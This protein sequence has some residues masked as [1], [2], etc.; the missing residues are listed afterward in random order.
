[1]KSLLL[2][3]AFLISASSV[4]GQD[5]QWKEFR[6]TK[7]NFYVQFPGEPLETKSVLGPLRYELTI[8]AQSEG[9]VGSRGP[10]F[11][12]LVDF[13]EPSELKP[14]MTNP[15]LSR[16]FDRL[17]EPECRDTGGSYVGGWRRISVD[18]HT[19]REIELYQWARRSRYTIISRMFIIKNR[20]Y[21]VWGIVEEPLTVEEQGTGKFDPAALANLRRFVESFSFIN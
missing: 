10:S 12:Y 2:L 5:A 19:G 3:A 9:V 4:F 11:Q 8:P 6:S 20:C 13:E 1:M 16:L 15:D 7:L 18:G 21:L 14:D 17:T